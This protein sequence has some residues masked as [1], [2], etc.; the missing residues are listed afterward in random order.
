[1]LA[2]FFAGVALLVSLTFAFGGETWRIAQRLPED[3]AGFV[4]PAA[5]GGVSAMMGLGGGTIGVP[6]MT[7][8]G[9]PPT[10]AIPTASAFGALIAIPGAAAA[11]LV[12]WHAPGLP[13]WSFG[14]VNL[15]GVVLIAPV[16]V[17]TARAGATL[18][19]MTDGNRLRVL[20][21]LFIVLMTGRMLFDALG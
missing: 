15:L 18:G 17:L 10:R 19:H 5:I 2:V 16:S 20:F 14:Y 11:I 9:A 4:L 1:M 12:G 21:A 3:G 7:L 8:C 6:A 13:P